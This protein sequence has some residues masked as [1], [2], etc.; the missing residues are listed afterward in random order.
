M[1]MPLSFFPYFFREVPIGEK[2]KRAYLALEAD[3]L[4]FSK[5]AVDAMPL[6]WGKVFLP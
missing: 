1:L 5:A 3:P 4:R 2:G 6:S